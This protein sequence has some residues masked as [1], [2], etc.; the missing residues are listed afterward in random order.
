MAV[1]PDG[2]RALSSAGDRTVRLWDLESRRQV[3]VLVGHSAA[4][5]EVAFLPDGKRGL[6]AGDDGTVRLWDLETG[7][8]LRQFPTEPN[9]HFICVAASPDGR[10]AIAGGDDGI[11]RVWEVDSGKERVRL[12]RH[13]DAVLAVA[14]TPDGRHVVSSGGGKDPAIRIWDVNSGREQKRVRELT[15]VAQALAVAPDGRRIAV[16][17]GDSTAEVCNLP[18][19]D[20]APVQ[21]NDGGSPL[22]RTLEGKIHDLAI[23]GGGRFILMV[24]TEA[25]KLAVFDV[26]S[27]DVV[28]TITLPAGNALVAAGA[29][30]FFIAYPDQKL[31][32][33]WSF[34]T[35]A[36]QGTTRPSPI[37]ARLNGLAMGNDCDG[38]LLA[39]W[40][41]DSSNNVIGQ[42]R[43]SF[44][45]PKTLTAL[46]VDS[47]TNGGFQGIGNVSP[48]G[49]SVQLHPFFQE[50]VHVRAFGRR[51]SVRNLAYK[52][53][54]FR[55]PDAGGARGGAPGHL[56]P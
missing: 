17:L 12:E 49:G 22:V 29:Q 26:N 37:R 54:A 35:M 48:S 42:A 55:L 46:K 2:R 25:R 16:A 31:I 9:R 44:L 21:V 34:E 39:V 52:R 40:L 15:S 11:V 38:P 13:G 8:Q 1:S 28:K 5:S 27:T 7:R 10:L 30:T 47:I 20:T 45:D 4:V 24:L 36:R 32:E 51:R 19:L 14:F 41:P 53:L 18:D 50:R 56:Q 33:R 3:R 6:S 43:F 23:G